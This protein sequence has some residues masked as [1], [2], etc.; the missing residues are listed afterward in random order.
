MGGKLPYFIGLFASQ[1]LAATAIYSWQS[2]A[3]T[4]IDCRW[5]DAL[6]SNVKQDVASCDSV[7]NRYIAKNGEQQEETKF[8][9]KFQKIRP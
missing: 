3:S 9:Q 6:R 8:A 1:S 7:S 2:T 4:I 5:I